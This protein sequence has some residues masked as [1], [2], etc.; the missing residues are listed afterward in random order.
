MALTEFSWADVPTI[1]TEV[2]RQGIEVSHQNFQIRTSLR[3]V[4]KDLGVRYLRGI[5]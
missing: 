5:S 2:S 3:S 1:T 4:H